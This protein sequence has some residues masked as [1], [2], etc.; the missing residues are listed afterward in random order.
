MEESF[1]PPKQRLG[2]WNWRWFDCSRSRVVAR[3]ELSANNP[4]HR[5]AARL[6]FRVNLKGL[7]WAANGDWERWAANPL[8][9]QR[10][11]STHVRR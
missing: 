2:G 6:R 11:L 10:A 5:I 9:R 7:D 4:L 3:V 8:L 1:R